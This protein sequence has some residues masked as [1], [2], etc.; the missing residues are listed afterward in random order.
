MIFLV[1][2]L[3]WTFTVYWMHRLAHAWSFMNQFHT[4]H[5]NQVNEET[6]QGFNWKNIFL[7]FDS[8]KSTVDQWLTEIIPTIIICLVTDQWWLFAAYYIW[9]AFIQENIEHNEKINLYPF[10]TSGKWHLVHHQDA[11]KNY[12]VFFPIWDIIFGTRAGANGYRK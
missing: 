2:I 6:I 4:D 1:T 3:G 7:W 12:G 8:W 10:L 9:A 5:H 11:T